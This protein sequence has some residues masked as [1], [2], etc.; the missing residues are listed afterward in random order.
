MVSLSLP[1]TYNALER[2]LV[3]GTLAFL[4]VAVGDHVHE[5]TNYLIATDMGHNCGKPVV[6]N[7]D[8]W[9]SLP[10]DTK[11][12][13]DGFDLNEKISKY[14]EIEKETFVRE[15]KAVK[16]KGLVIL[17]LSASDVETLKEIAKEKVW[18][19]YAKDLEKKVFKGIKPYNII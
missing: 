4:T 18:E 13:I 17:E 2:G 7:L 19:P 16:D 15:M 10:E 3:K 12:V 1:E 8:T 14:A 9:N 5:V 11:K 6:M